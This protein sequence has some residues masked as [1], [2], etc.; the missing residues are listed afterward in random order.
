MVSPKDFD[1]HKC[2]YVLLD[3]YR[4]GDVHFLTAPNN[5]PYVLVVF[6]I[7]NQGFGVPCHGHTKLPLNQVCS[8]FDG[9]I[10]DALGGY[11]NNNIIILVYQHVFL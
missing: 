8:V 10:I 2:F 9:N 5:L 1:P 4:N 7:E 6:K 3:P 11:A